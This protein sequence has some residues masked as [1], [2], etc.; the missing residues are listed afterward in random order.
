MENFSTLLV[1]MIS[2]LFG[3]LLTWV[4]SEVQQ[5]KF[6]YKIR[7]ALKDR[8]HVCLNEEFLMTEM[9]AKKIQKAGYAPDVIFA[10]CPGGAM[11]AEWLSRQFLGASKCP[12][13]VRT[14]CVQTKRIGG[15]VESLKCVIKEKIE[16]VV[17][18]LSKSEEVL[19][20][21]DIS[22]GGRTLEVAHDFLCRFFSKEKVSTATL[23]CH[24]D[25]HVKPRFYSAETDKTVRFDW[26][27]S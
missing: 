22:R 19:I 15:G 7:E 4:V 17:G 8:R 2:V 9:L 23:F 11:I 5:R 20:V 26:K 14:I 27:E 25:A 18:G 21:N 6:L 16:E 1:V 12:I 10:I 3:G 13:P 24:V